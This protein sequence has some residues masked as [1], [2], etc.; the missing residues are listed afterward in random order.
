[1][2][3]PIHAVVSQ[4]VEGAVVAT[5]R[6]LAST[7]RLGLRVLNRADRVKLETAL[8]SGRTF[9]LVDILGREWLVR[10]TSGMGS[11]MLRAAPLS[12]ESTG[13]RD[14]HVIDVEFTEVR[15]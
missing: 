12:A 13:L 2:A 7:H 9:R 5:S 11:T 3:E 15:R 8:R 10:N 6:P 4:Q 14:A 1:M